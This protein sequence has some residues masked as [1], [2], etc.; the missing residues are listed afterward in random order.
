ML[1]TIIYGTKD[2]AYN[3]ICEFIR[4]TVSREGYKFAFIYIN[5]WYGTL[6]PFNKPVQVFL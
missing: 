6:T 2:I 5:R 1:N 3:Q 4:R